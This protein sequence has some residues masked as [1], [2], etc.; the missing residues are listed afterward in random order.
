MTS[1]C[2]TDFWEVVKCTSLT[3][4]DTDI[5]LVGH[6]LISFFFFLNNKCIHFVIHVDVLINFLFW[7]LYT[8]QHLFSKKHR[9][10]CWQAQMVTSL[11]KTRSTAT[12]CKW[13]CVTYSTATWVT[14]CKWMR[15]VCNLCSK[16]GYYWF[17]LSWQAY[18][19]I[20]IST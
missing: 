17:A 1:P 3:F 4:I 12:G 15:V 18:I 2:I 5:P 14:C 10:L 11:N 7:F 20:K 13:T 9:S 8:G 19:A 6:L 16:Q